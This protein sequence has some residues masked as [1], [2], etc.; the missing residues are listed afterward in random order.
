MLAWAKSHAFLLPSEDFTQRWQA[1][2]GVCG[3]ECDV[4][5]DSANGYYIKRN[6]TLA[7]EDWIQFFESVRMHNHLF[8][9]TEYTLLGFMVVDGILNGVVSQPAIASTRA[10]IRVEVMEYMGRFGF[11]H[12]GNDNYE[13]ETIL[14]QDLHDENVLIG[15]D[16]RLYFID[17]CIYIK[18]GMPSPLAE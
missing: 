17:T 5:Y 8:P 13:N 16:G 18:A 6:N 14:I 10:A 4:Y 9:D 1:Q 15:Y 12:V 3:Q 2:G 7:Y 11:K